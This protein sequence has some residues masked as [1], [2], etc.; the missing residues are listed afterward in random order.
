MNHISTYPLAQTMR[1]TPSLSYRLVLLCMSCLA[2]VCLWLGGLH[3]AT[4]SEQD[5]SEIQALR[6]LSK[7]FTQIAEQASPAVVYIRADQR[8]EPRPS[9]GRQ[10]FPFN[11]DFM[12]RFFGERVPPQ[13]QPQQD[14]EPQ[15]RSGQGSGFIVSADGEILTNHHVVAGADR[16]MVTLH[17][18]REFPAKLVGSD[19]K[20][21]LAV[22]KIEANDLPKLPLGSSANLR[23][24]EWV[25]AI[26][27]PFGLSHTITSGIVS[28]KGRSSVGITDYEDFIQTDAAINPGNSGGPL[29]NLDGEVVGINTAIFSRSG[30]YMGIGFAIPIDMAAQIFEQIRTGKSVVRGYLGVGIQ[31]LS[32]ELAESF[33]LSTQD[34][35]VVT[36]VEPGSS[37]EQAGVQSQDIIVAVNGES[38]KSVGPF[39]NTIALISPGEKTLLTIWRDGNKMDIEVTMGQ[40]EQAVAATS[41]TMNH[42]EKWGIEIAEITDENREEF[43]LRTQDGLVVTAVEPRSRAAANGVRPGQLL[44]GINTTAVKDLESLGEAM[45]AAAQTKRPIRLVLRQG[46]WTVLAVM[47]HNQ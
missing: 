2:I 44:V 6:Q 24:G 25:M 13:R 8:I 41:E 4:A 17:D 26:G 31:D 45:E 23:I 34:G 12:E 38:M 33:G 5:S 1:S 7:G 39:R 37:A 16:L 28:A 19:E 21:D 27:N 43:E 22:L 20:T 30:G 36:Q 15:Y 32:K 11:N 42:F 10:G 9:R 29:L 46:N 35:I 47:P 3:H 18:G 40:R 14:E